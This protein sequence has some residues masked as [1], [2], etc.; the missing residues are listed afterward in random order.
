MAAGNEILF[1]RIAIHNGLITVEQLEECLDLQRERA[2]SKHVGQVMIER[3]LVDASQARAIVTIQRRKL[4]R[5]RRPGRGEEERRF[6]EKLASDGVVDRASLERAKAAQAEM[7]SKGLY[8]AL[9][10]ILIQQGVLSLRRL[11]EEQTKFT[12]TELQ[13]IKCGKKYRAT[14]FHPWKEALCRKCGGRLAPPG[15]AACLSADTAPPASPEEPAPGS[16]AAIDVGESL[17]LAAERDL[18]IEDAEDEVGPGDETSEAVVVPGESPARSASFDAEAELPSGLRK[19]RGG[20]V[21]AFRPRVGDTIGGYRLEE[22]LGEGGM[23]LV[24]R[25]RHQV[26]DKEA[27]IKILPAQRVSEPTQVQRFLNEARAAAA[28]EHP[29]IVAVQHVGEERGAYFI[30]MQYVRGKAV[31]LMLTE[32]RF[33]AEESLPLIRQ[34]A[35]ALDYAHRRNMVHRDIKPA[36]IMVDEAGHVTI[37]DFGLTK[38]IASDLHLTSAGFVVGTVTYMSPEQSNGRP[39]DGRSDLYSLGTTWFEMLTGRLPFYGDTPWSVLLARLKEPA[40]DIRSIR[41]DLPES[42]CR[43]IM[44][45]LERE[46]DKR[47]ASAAAL[48]K[49]LDV[50]TGGVGAQ[51]REAGRRRD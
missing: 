30:V 24:F 41:Q 44:R 20:A 28:L 5:G 18:D 38:N 23:G 45:M 7:E 36:N 10:D 46:P 27:A 17:E 49:A 12:R 31:K 40:P 3:G 50:L 34:T 4:R 32:R 29:N 22:K 21:A 35:D 16:E 48:V 19:P 42:I 8:P 9:G 47:P 11:H 43:I 39:V 6:A 14:G 37:V 26:L 13:C 15:G 1:G 2:P 33:D 25:G 51:T